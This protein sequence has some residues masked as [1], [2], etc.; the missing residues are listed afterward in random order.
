M[1]KLLLVLVLVVA[2]FGCDEEEYSSQSGYW[3]DSTFVSEYFNFSITYP[4]N[5]T[6][7]EEKKMAQVLGITVAELQELDGQVASYEY[8]IAPELD[9]PLFQFYVE[10]Y[11]FTVGVTYDDFLNDLVTQLNA[12]KDTY[13]AVGMIQDLTINEV[14]LKKI[15]LIAYAGYFMLRQDLYLFQRDSY[16]GTLMVTYTDGMAQEVEDIIQTI[17]YANAKCGTK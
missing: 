11:R 15:P 7:Y 6:Q 1:K 9:S 4:E 5:Y 12:E 2:L 3:L 16:V 8:M 17:V 10:K 13:Y 14:K